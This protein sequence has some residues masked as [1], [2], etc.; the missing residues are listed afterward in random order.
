MNT[1]SEVSVGV[2]FEFEAAHLLPK[3]SGK[4]R[5]IHGH[6]Y[7]VEISLVGQ[8][9]YETGMIM[10]FSEVKAAIEPIIERLDHSLIAGP[11]T[12]TPLLA[13]L[14]K[15]RYDVTLVPFQPTVENLAQ[16]LLEEG[17]KALGRPLFVRVYETPNNWAEACFHG[18][19]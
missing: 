2:H 3:H 7:V 13:M 5:N 11:D 10:D 1:R 12:P 17:T 6:H 4:C 8:V 18:E 15:F 19:S 16:Y 14:G 9:D